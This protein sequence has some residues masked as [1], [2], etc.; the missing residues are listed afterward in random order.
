MKLI[1]LIRSAIC[2]K[3]IRHT[4]TPTYFS[5]GVAL[6]VIGF[7][8]TAQAQE[9]LDYQEAQERQERQEG[10]LSEQLAEP[11]L[12]P[13]RQSLMRIATAHL[14]AMGRMLRGEVDRHRHCTV[15]ATSK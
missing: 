9:A 8:C 5:L 14:S 12:V 2:R 7:A 1:D 11:G 15:S 13:Y 10:A 3:R 6:I 4:V